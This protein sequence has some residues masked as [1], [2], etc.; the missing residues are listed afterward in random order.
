MN[1][2]LQDAPQIY[3]PEFFKDSPIRLHYGEL[4]L[5]VDQVIERDSF[6]DRPLRSLKNLCIVG[7]VG[8]GLR[9][10]I[11]TFMRFHR[12]IENQLRKIVSSGAM[13]ERDQTSEDKLQE[14]LERHQQLGHMMAMTPS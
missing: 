14:L 9:W 8:E 1:T 5:V 3:E 11:D 13:F 7:A 4:M 6:D 2:V 12:D 10:T